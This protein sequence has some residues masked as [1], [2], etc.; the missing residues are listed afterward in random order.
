MKG[1]SL[2]GGDA[3]GL[4]GRRVGAPEILRPAA[5]PEAK[6]TFKSTPDQDDIQPCR[7]SRIRYKKYKDDAGLQ[8]RI[9]VR[10]RYVI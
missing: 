1:E 10:S 9:R 5:V 4:R 3:A 6:T 2:Q 7:A 8:I